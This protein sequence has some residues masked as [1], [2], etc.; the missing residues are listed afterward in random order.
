MPLRV[1]RDVLALL[2][3]SWDGSVHIDVVGTQRDLT[4]SQK[5]PPGANW[6]SRSRAGIWSRAQVPEMVLIRSYVEQK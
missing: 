6:V 1:C 3:Q 5:T 2:A 4:A